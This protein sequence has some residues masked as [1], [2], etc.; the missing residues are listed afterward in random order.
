MFQAGRAPRRLRLSIFLLQCFGVRDAVLGRV[1][2]RSKK[3]VSGS[4]FGSWG[5]NNPDQHGES[6]RL[7]LHSPSP[8]GAD[9]KHS[10]DNEPST[11]GGYV[12]RRSRSAQTAAVDPPPA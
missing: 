9:K 3:F 7:E 5:I 2:I 8:H 4:C 6:A 10:L 1:R 11:L 12:S